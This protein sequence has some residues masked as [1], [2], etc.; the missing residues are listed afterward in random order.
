MQGD[1]QEKGSVIQGSN[2]LQVPGIVMEGV[3]HDLCNALFLTSEHLPIMEESLSSGKGDLLQEAINEMK[4]A[5]N[6]SVRLV[7]QL[8]SLVRN[9]GPARNRVDVKNLLRTGSSL[10]K[11]GSFVT[12]DVQFPEHDLYVDCNETDILRVLMNVLLNSRQ[13]VR[14]NGGVIS[15]TLEELNV[16]PGDGGSVTP[17]AFVRVTISDNGPGIPDKDME[18]IFKEGFT[19]KKN[20]TGVGLATSLRIIREHGGY[21]EVEPGAGKGA[22]FKIYLPAFLDN[23]G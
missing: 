1:D 16:S 7:E 21:I 15:V 10:V 2:S 11:A 19:T 3:L 12:V 18:H 23:I 6:Y 9:N 13:A 8:K 17:G 20:G 5:T 14:G 22:T 4:K